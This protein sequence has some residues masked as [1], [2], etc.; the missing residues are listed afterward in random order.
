MNL[1][2]EAQ[3]A[4]RCLLGRNSNDEAD[5][6]SVQVGPKEHTQVT[7]TNSWDLPQSGV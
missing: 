7:S 4:V 6:E 1:W 3:E 5:H 2:Q